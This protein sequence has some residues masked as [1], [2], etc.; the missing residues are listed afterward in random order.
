MA[1][2]TSFSPFFDHLCRV[3]DHL[4]LEEV[5]VLLHCEDGETEVYDPSQEQFRSGS[6]YQSSVPGGPEGLK[7]A[8]RHLVQRLA[9]TQDLEESV[10]RLLRLQWRNLTRKDRR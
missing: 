6:V 9:L 7:A 5:E 8:A 4:P 10:A 1:D 2:R 3:A